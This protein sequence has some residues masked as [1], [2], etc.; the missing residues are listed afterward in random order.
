[1][2][3][4]VTIS[5]L[6]LQKNCKNSTEFPCDPYPVS[7]Y[8]LTSVKINEPVLTRK[9]HTLFRFPWFLPTVASLTQNPPRTPHYI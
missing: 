9:T 6:D 5:V 8:Y 1:M 3:I 7:R 2:P 4:S